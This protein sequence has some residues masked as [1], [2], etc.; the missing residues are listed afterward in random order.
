VKILRTA[1]ADDILKLEQRKLDV[2]DDVILARK[3]FLVVE[4]ES[5]V[6]RVCTESDLSRQ[7]GGGG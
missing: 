6:C 5:G 4:L 7:E 3:K 1:V 2:F